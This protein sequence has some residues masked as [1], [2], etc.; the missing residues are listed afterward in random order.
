MTAE[1]DWDLE[2]CDEFKGN[3]VYINN[4]NEI[5]VQEVLDGSVLEVYNMVV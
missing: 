2:D 5:H 3:L 4:E 1:C